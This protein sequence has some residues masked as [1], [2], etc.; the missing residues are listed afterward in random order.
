MLKVII[1]WTYYPENKRF[2]SFNA[3]QKK[4]C[5]YF[6]DYDEYV[7]YIIESL[8]FSELQKLRLNIFSK[9]HKYIKF[10]KCRE[11][12]IDWEVFEYYKIQS[13]ILEIDI[14]DFALLLPNKDLRKKFFIWDSIRERYYLKSKFINYIQMQCPLM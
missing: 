8:E 1:N 6:Y 9:Y 3:R 10:T 4:D 2:S 12:N 11:T 7:H 14:N 13:P 5:V